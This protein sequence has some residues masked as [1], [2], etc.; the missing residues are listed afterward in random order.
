MLLVAC[1]NAA[2]GV[3]RAARCATAAHGRTCRVPTASA[4]CV[5]AELHSPPN[6]ACGHPSAP[7]L[8]QGVPHRP[9]CFEYPSAAPDAMRTLRLPRAYA[10]RGPPS[11]ETAAWRRFARRFNLHMHAPQCAACSA[12]GGAAAHQRTSAV[13]AEGRTT[14]TAT[15]SAVGADASGMLQAHMLQHGRTCCNTAAHVATRP[16]T[17]QENRTYRN[18]A[19]DVT[20]RVAHAATWSHMLHH[21]TACRDAANRFF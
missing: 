12:G 15:A 16:H 20:P 6:K 14:A 17:L 3:L 19:V 11:V 8:S 10:G 7:R 18:T 5:R 13:T 2:R 1:C 4:S 21:S 9:S